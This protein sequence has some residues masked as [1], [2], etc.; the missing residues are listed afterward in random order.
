MY[1]TI[2]LNDKRNFIILISCRVS[3]LTPQSFRHSFLIS[4]CL[5]SESVL[6]TPAH[7]HSTPST[8]AQSE[9]HYLR[10]EDIRV[11][12]SQ[13]LDL[14]RAEAAVTGNSL[15]VSLGWKIPRLV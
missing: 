3:V 1:N 7:G 13:G 5:S 10:V 8:T 15:S 12:L 2:K 6:Q 9:K 11:D 14:A 4:A